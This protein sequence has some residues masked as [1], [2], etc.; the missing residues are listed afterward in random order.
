MLGSRR[1]TTSMRPQGASRWRSCSAAPRSATTALR[2][3]P[4]TGSSRRSRPRRV[5]DP[6]AVLIAARDEEMTIAATVEALRAQFPA[7]DVIVADD[8]SRDATAAEAERAGARVLELP[9]RGKGQ[10]LTLAELAAPP[11]AIVLADADLVGDL[12]PLADS[13]AD[14]AVAA[15]AESRR[16]P[17]GIA[18]RF[19]RELRWLR[20]GFT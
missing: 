17:L 18:K 6:A 20:A 7:A 12:R 9:R 3:P 15:F 13:E 4:T 5:A 2:R 11:G 1:S 8:G 10:A 14:L 16:P 19:A